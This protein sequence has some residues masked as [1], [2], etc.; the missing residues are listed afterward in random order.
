M[1][2]LRTPDY[3]LAALAAIVIVNVCLVLHYQA[4]SL[5]TRYLPRIAQ[6]PRRRVLALMFAVF[7]IHVVEIWLFG[8]G[9]ALLTRDPTLGAIQGLP[10]TELPDFVYFSAMTYTT[11]GF[12]DVVPVG[13][14]RFLAGLEAVTGLVMIAWSASYTFLAMHRDW[15]SA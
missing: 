7:T 8:A 13:A 1:S 5:C 4:L 14:I 2:Y 6:R 15:P 11:V 10:T 3:W 9:Y 12:G